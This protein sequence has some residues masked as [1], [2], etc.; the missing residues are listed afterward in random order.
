MHRDN[1]AERGALLDAGLP[2]G[3]R[4]SQIVG[5]AVALVERPASGRPPR[6]RR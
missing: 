5:A 6:Y 2:N 4:T 3:S 1:R